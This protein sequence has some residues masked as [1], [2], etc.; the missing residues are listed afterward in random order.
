MKSEEEKVRIC[1]KYDGNS[2]VAKYNT[3]ERAV[4]NR[5]L[6]IKLFMEVV[7]INES[8]KRLVQ[9][10]CSVAPYTT[11]NHGSWGPI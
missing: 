3:L 5:V 4:S 7:R 1:V 10:K 8:S 6:S 2:T 11:W 9:T